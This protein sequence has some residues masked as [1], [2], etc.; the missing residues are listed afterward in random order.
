M[1]R[2]VRH[3][4]ALRARIVRALPMLYAAGPDPALDRPAHVRAGSG[5]ARVGGRIAVVQDDASF[6]ALVDPATGIADAVTLPADEGGLRQFDDAR[7][8]KRHK[9]DLETCVA[10]GD[11]GDELLVALGSGSTAA[12]EKI[13]V[14]RGIGGGAPEVRVVDA[15]ALY[16]SLRQT[17]DFA[18]S[19]LNVEGAAVIGGALRLFNRGN[20]APRE[21]LLPAD[22]SC[23]L[24]FP[25]FL[26]YLRDPR[27]HRPPSPSRVARYDLGEMGGR[28]LTFTDAAVLDGRVWFTGAAEDSPDATRDGPVAGS[29]IGVLKGEGGRWA[30]IEDAGGGR[31]GGKVEG[32]LPLSP[33]AA[34]V[35]VD[36]DAPALPS[37]LCQ[38]ELAGEWG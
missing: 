19:E 14:V 34:L 10:I 6:V 32:V 4:P 37:E 9:L 36:R 2:T 1:K 5:I 21:G 25:A 33:T 8:N 13:V 26:A 18:G 7:G 38:V 11:A 27:A 15:S 3:D 30:M 31:F 24:D 28:P 17:I 35:V 16:A 22:A 29:A 20:G 12:R 23:D